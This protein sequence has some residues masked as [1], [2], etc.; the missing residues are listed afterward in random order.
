M[1][2]SRPISLRIQYVIVDFTYDKFRYIRC[3]MMSCCMCTCLRPNNLKNEISLNCI[4]V[5]ILY[6]TKCCYIGFHYT[7]SCWM[8]LVCNKCA[9]PQIFVKVNM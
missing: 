3:N 6:L 5:I 1:T 7:L 8:T 4:S 2:F 9:M